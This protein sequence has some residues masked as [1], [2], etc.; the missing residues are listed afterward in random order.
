MIESFED[1]TARSFS[2][3]EE[4]KYLNMKNDYDE[5][6]KQNDCNGLLKI[7]NNF[8]LVNEK[9]LNEIIQSNEKKKQIEK[10]KM[11][12]ENKLKENKK[13]TQQYNNFTN[14]RKIDLNKIKE[15]NKDMN[16][17]F[18][19]YIVFSVLFLVTQAG[20]IYAL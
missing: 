13:T 16:N 10:V 9:L 6:K 3:I 2:V 17:Y 14:M 12:T 15:Q 19:F 4:K 18:T 11:D 1:H 7:I 5:L 20:I 8:I